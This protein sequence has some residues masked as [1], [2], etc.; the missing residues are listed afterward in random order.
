[1]NYGLCSCAGEM[2]GSPTPS[3]ITHTGSLPSSPATSTTTTT[4]QPTPSP[5]VCTSLFQVCEIVNFMFNSV[6]FSMGQGEE[7]AACSPV[8]APYFDQTFNLFACRTFGAALS[9]VLCEWPDVWFGDL[10]A[11]KSMVK[12]HVHD[13]ECPYWDQVSLNNSNPN[14][15]CHKL[16][17]KGGLAFQCVLYCYCAVKLLFI[18]M[19]SSPYNMQLIS[20]VD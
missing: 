7:S 5:G 11:E 15:W 16:V 8:S 4:Q 18:W 17:G 14:P 3:L 1:M 2:F 10:Q 19:S 13:T 20:Q 6:F 12:H 9:S